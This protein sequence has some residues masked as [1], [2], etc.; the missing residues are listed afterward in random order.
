MHPTLF[1][2]AVVAG[3]I[4]ALNDASG[5]VSSFMLSV[6]GL[7]A[8]GLIEDHQ[9]HEEDGCGGVKEESAVVASHVY[10]VDWKCRTT[11]LIYS[12]YSFHRLLRCRFHDWYSLDFIGPIYTSENA[13]NP[14][15]QSSV[16]TQ[17]RL[18]GNLMSGAAVIVVVGVT[19]ERTA[20][21]SILHHHQ[22]D[23]L[24]RFFPPA[25]VIFVVATWEMHFS[26]SWEMP[27]CSELPS[28]PRLSVLKSHHFIA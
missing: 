22:S 11:N 18:E 21:S 5:S 10:H 23:E 12:L 9:Q 6:T 15:Q 26:F 2:L 8:L 20:E 1:A 7:G 13:R 27:F 24:K 4:R 19:V 14:W 17:K 25:G 3:A 16:L 28:S